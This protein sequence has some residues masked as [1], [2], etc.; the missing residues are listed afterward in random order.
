MPTHYI[1]ITIS[2]TINDISSNKKKK[3]YYITIKKGLFARIQIIIINMLIL[4][5]KYFFLFL[6]LVTNSC[7]VFGICN[8]LESKSKDCKEIGKLCSWV[9]HFCKIAASN[10][11]VKLLKKVNKSHI[12]NKIHHQFKLDIVTCNKGF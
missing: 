6:Y 9:I 3:I 10:E 2:V 11:L 12:N 1:H 4:K 8:K 7:K 5:I